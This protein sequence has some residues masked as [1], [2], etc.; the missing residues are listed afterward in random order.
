MD[1]SD[2]SGSVQSSQ[3]P[4]S[5]HEEELE[6]STSCRGC[7]K[8]ISV[9]LSLF[10]KRSFATCADAGEYSCHFKRAL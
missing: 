7:S 10:E 1:P 8:T 2:P 5:Q 6:V 3:R 9:R 4:F